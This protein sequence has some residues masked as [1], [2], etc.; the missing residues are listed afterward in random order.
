M[1][2]LLDVAKLVS[3]R[4]QKFAGERPYVATGAMDDTGR[5]DPVPVT[6]GGRP[7]RADLQVQPGD[8]CMARMRSTLKVREVAQGDEAFIL[9]TGFAVFRPLPG[10]LEPSY[11]RHWLRSPGLQAEKDRLC[12]GA[13]QPAITNGGLEELK[14][15]LVPIEEQRRIAAVLD[16]ADALRA[17]RR[18]ALAKLDTL[19]QAV[20]ADMFGR[21]G[22]YDRKPFGDLLVQSPRNGISPSSTGTVSGRVLTLDA[23]TRSG[24]DAGCQKE[25][26]FVAPHA[27]DKTVDKRDF[28]ICRG[29]G[30]LSLVARAA[31]PDENLP[32]VAFPDTII[33]ARPDPELVGRAYLAHI[34]TLDVVRRQ[35][36]A[37]ARTTNGTHKIN[38]GAVASIEIPTPPLTEQGRFAD[39][40]EAIGVAAKAQRI[41]L[42]HLDTLFVALQQQAF[43]GEL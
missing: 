30:N 8:V 15:P 34:W 4:V 21:L 7:S 17:K 29:N 14:I 37:L 32:G 2:P 22:A 24:F 11:L 5:I 16:A 6:Y 9:S 39:A 33:A 12:T 41:S 43:R 26:T 38:Q 31:F 36:E 18:E 40:V 28:L 19:T 23:I 3:E 13:V 1:R 35:V 25:G 27:R 42:E 10:V 20:F